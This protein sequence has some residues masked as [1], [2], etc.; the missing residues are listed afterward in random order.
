MTIL[1]ATVEV[2]QCD[3]CGGV[4]LPAGDDWRHETETGECAQFGTPVICRHDDCGFPA[5]VGGLACPGHS[6]LSY[7]PGLYGRSRV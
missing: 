7:A 6:E 1:L 4:L 3:P 2:A 5:A